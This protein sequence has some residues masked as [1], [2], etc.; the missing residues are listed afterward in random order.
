MYLDADQL[1]DGSILTGFDLCIVG[2]GAAGI[3]LA[4]QLIT[5]SLKVLVVTSGLRTDKGE[6]SPDTPRQ[7]FY[8]GSVGPFLQQV[9]PGFLTSTRL[10]AYGGTTNHFAFYAHP[11][12]AEDLLPRPGY[13]AAHWPI[14][15]EELN[16]YYPAANAFGSYG[17]FNYD[18]LAFWEQAL[19]SE[20]LSSLPEDQLQNLIWHAQY[21]QAIYQ[22]QTQCGAL[23]QAARNV[24]VLF[25]A[26]VL[27]I[28]TTPGQQQVTGL[29]CATLAQQQPGIHF[30]VAARRYVL[31]QG[32][33]ETVRLLKLSNNL[34]DNA[35]QHLGRGFMLHP[36]IQNAASVSLPTD[37]LP[38]AGKFYQQQ[39]V[40]LRP[41]LTP[42]GEPFYQPVTTLPYQ[43]AELADSLQLTAWGV[44][45]PRPAAVAAEKIGSFH[46]NLSF[47]FVP[48]SKLT[49]LTLSMNWESAPNEDSTITLDLTKL[50][51]VF[52][53]P[54]VCVDWRLL[55]SDKQTIRRGLALLEQYFAVRGGQDFKLLTDLSGG[56][57]H[58]TFD[59]TG[60]NPARLQTGDHHMGAVRMAAAPAD[61][62]VDANLKV[63]TVEN[64]YVVGSGVFPTSGHANPTLTIVALALRLADH[65]QGQT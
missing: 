3:A 59:P 33:V 53:Q 48:R 38:V 57:D 6:P 5:S 30:G 34:G 12:A 2:A 31:A 18:D 10:N 8:R 9:N 35:K 21:D 64:L 43:P 45:A 55:E 50:D 11:L 36:L 22:F 16:R 32:G 52:G 19:G 46:T 28:E 47:N 37:L 61:G 44:L 7:Q 26:T 15:I 27:Q 40:T 63:H 39:Q 62:I 65:L 24:T 29:R 13:R 1:P 20:P 4:Q 42:V 58:W 25:N 60:Q 49:T 14:G 23:L 17:P 41:Q 51:P 54:V 56:P